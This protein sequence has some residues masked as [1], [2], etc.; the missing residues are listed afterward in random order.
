V[1]PELAA[2]FIESC[3]SIA[4]LPGAHSEDRFPRFSPLIAMPPNDRLAMDS[5]DKHDSP[6][7]RSD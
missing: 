5:V 7:R 4:A 2:A 6:V 1:D 3:P